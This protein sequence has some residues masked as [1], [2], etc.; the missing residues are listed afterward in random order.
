MILNFGKYKGEDLQDIPIQ[1][2]EWLADECQFDD[3][4]EAAEEE[5]QRRK[6]HYEEY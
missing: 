3:V 4:K 6:D 1:Y 5:L 2:L